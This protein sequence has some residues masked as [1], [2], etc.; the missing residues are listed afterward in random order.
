MYNHMDQSI[1]VVIL[2]SS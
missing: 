1:D 2:M